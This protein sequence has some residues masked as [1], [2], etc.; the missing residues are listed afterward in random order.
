MR[1]LADYIHSA[2]EMK[3]YVGIYLTQAEADLHDLSALCTEGGCAFA[4]TA[5]RMKGGAEMAGAYHLA[6][7]CSCAQDMDLSR[8]KDRVELMADI[9]REFDAVKMALENRCS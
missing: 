1:I 9:R 4:E 5:H 6:A 3:E 7:L 8:K 2:D